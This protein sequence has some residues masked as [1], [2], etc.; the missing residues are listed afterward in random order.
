MSKK[1]TEA[2]IESLVADGRD[3]IVFDLTTPGFGIRVTAAG[4]KLFI[5]RTRVAGRRRYVA[6]GAFPDVKLGDA[7]REAGRVLDALRDGRDPAQE[8]QERLRAAEAGE[9]TIAVLGERWLKEVVEPKR[10]PRTAADY[11][12]L[13]E[14]KIGPALGH[15]V[16]SRIGRDDVIKWH[17]AMRKTPRRANYALA[18]L[19]AL[20]NFAEDVGLRTPHSNPARRIEMYREGKRER[21]LSEAEIAKAAEGITKAERSKKIGPHPAAGLRLALFTGARSGEILAARWAHIDWERR[22]IRLP[23]SKSGD[24]RTIHLSDAALEVLKTLPKVGPFII[25][26]AKPKEAFKNLTRA[27]LAARKLVGL[28]D[29]RLHDLRHSYA[30]LAAGRGVSLHMIGKLLGHKVPATTAR[31]AHLAR[32]AVAGINDELGAAMTAAIDKAAPADG[33][34]VRLKKRK[35]ATHQ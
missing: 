28:D 33:N 21:F 35:R 31:Y 13:V 16:V 20:L 29:V 2:F 19:K 22:F 32:D 11:R 12:G 8:R 6:L 1:L 15:I 18:V 27:W 34:V 9:T 30:S 14:Q 5:A 23:D 26:G 10:K 25:A 4:Q 3:R 24:A 17:G 7:R